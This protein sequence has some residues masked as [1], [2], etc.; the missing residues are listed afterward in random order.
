M[1]VFLSSLSHADKT[2]SIHFVRVLQRLGHRVFECG[3]PR[4]EDDLEHGFAAGA[5]FDPLTT[6]ESLARVAGFA[7]DLFLYIEPQGLIPRGLERAG[8]PTACVLCDTHRDLPSR[9]RLA[10]LFDYVFLYHRNYVGSFCEHPPANVRWLPYACDLELFRPLGTPRDFDVAFVGHSA[11]NRA[12]VLDKL[13]SRYRMNE[14]RYYLQREIPEVYSRAKIVLN[15]PAA[16][17]L[18]FRT[19]EAMA[20]GALLLTRRIA[21]GQEVLFEEG[22]HFAAYNDEQEMFAKVHYYLTHPEAREAIAAAGLAEVQ[23]AHRLEERIEEL[24]AAVHAGDHGAPLRSLAPYQ[25]DRQY[26]WLYEYGRMLQPGVDL[27]REAR[28]RGRPWAALTPPVLRSLLR[29][30]LR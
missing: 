12:A 25:V 3:V 10:R 19:F 20:C 28:R 13:A 5:G 6:L 14:R 4:A 21:N 2:E 16:D 27:I 15:L 30:V 7:P 1:N 22:Q 8:C 29:A 18:N 23:K 11:R 24:L 17:D 26:A 9:I